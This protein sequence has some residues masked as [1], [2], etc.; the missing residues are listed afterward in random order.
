MNKLPLLILCAGFGSRMLNLTKDTPKPL[1]KF[2]NKTLLGNTIEFFKDIGFSEFFINTHYLHEK[3]QAYIDNQYSNY[4]INIIYEPTILGTGGAIKN[5]FACTNSNNICVVNADVF[6]QINNKLDISNF[7]ED[8]NDI[9]YCKILLSKKKNFIGL[10][11]TTG[12]FIIEN[13]NV[14]K[15]S[16]GKEIIFYTGFQI[17]S[18]NIFK[19]TNKIFSMNKI[20][21]NLISEK[22]LRGSLT[23]SKILHIGDKNSYD[24]L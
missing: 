8:Y 3:I 19:N 22:K 9:D 15:W 10:K 12:D 13:E 6:W 18:K 21:D 20:W 1:L 23:K 14:V 16:Q 11:N 17:V 4:P 5:T 7:L 24:M 2:H